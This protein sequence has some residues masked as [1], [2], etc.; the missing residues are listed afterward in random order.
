MA[1]MIAAVWGSPEAGGN[2]VVNMPL[3]LSYRGE[4]GV[5]GAVGGGVRL[6]LGGAVEG[7]SCCVP[8]PSRATCTYVP[9]HG[10][11]SHKTFDIAPLFCIPLSAKSTIS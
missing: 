3:P 6:P 9:P 10:Y 4:A 5:A 2:A 11:F 8:V 7:R 1:P